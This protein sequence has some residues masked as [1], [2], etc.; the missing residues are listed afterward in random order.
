[1][2]VLGILRSITLLPLKCWYYLIN[3]IQFRVHGVSV[4]KKWQIKGIIFIINRGKIKIGDHFNG[5]SSKN[6]NPIGGDIVLRLV[7]RKKASLIMGNNV[8]ISNSTIVCW[9]KIEMG[10]NINIGGGCK[11]WDTDFHSTDPFD[12]VGS[13]NANVKTSPIKICDYAFIG[14]GSIILKGVKIGKNAVVAAGSV[15][16]KSIPENE[17]WGGN[18]ARYIRRL[19]STLN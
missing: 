19:D 16:T 15:V 12:R 3:S 14:G 17:I 18:P 2:S 10:N 1:M 13:D 4:G 5:N 7:V 9:N 8:G 6:A 11:I